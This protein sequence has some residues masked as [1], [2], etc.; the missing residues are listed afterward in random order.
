MYS[1]NQLVRI[2]Y[3]C[4]IFSLFSLQTYG[5]EAPS[6]LESIP[7]NLDTENVICLPGIDPA[8]IVVINGI[9]TLNC[10]GHGLNLNSEIRLRIEM[11]VD[12]GRSSSGP[13]G[14]DGREQ[15]ATE[16]FY[17]TVSID[18]NFDN[19]ID[20]SERVYITS[21]NGE[22]GNIVHEFVYDYQTLTQTS[23]P[24]EQQ[25][26]DFTLAIM[27]SQTEIDGS[28]NE[29]VSDYYYLYTPNPEE[30]YTQ[31]YNGACN[32]AY[33]NQANNTSNKGVGPIKDP[34][35][36]PTTRTCGTC[37][38]NNGFDGAS[39]T[40]RRFGQRSESFKLYP[41]PANDVINIDYYSL[42]NEDLH[43]QVLNIMGQLLINKNISLEQRNHQHIEIPIQ[44]LPKGA[45]II[46]I[47]DGLIVKTKK[48]MKR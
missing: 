10:E 36:C 3:A 38:D 27:V 18:R 43:I 32:C 48:F 45:Y 7:P 46:Q 17:L 30:A 24:E 37:G 39:P 19:V 25:E 34:T 14:T 12:L 35:C 31:E 6:T 2:G 13:G 44:V 9:E 15:R 21:I 23:V 1:T 26:D 22:K 41:N 5:Q 4:L 29:Y 16:E 42:S 28:C 40:N 8:G 20:A 11:E 33:E 47:S